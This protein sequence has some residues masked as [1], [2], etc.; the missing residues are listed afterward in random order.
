MF[1]SA[2]HLAPLKQKNLELLRQYQQ[3]HSHKIRNTIVQQNIGLVRKEVYRW[4]HNC[5]ETYEDLLQVGSLGLIR[6]IERFDLSKG[7][8]FS[9]F[10]LP[11]IRGE[12]Q[13]YLRD[14]S[15]C[16]RVPRQWFNLEKKAKNVIHQLQVYLK[17]QP[18]DLEIATQMDISI[19]EWDQIKLASQNRSLLSL[20]APIRDEWEGKISLG[21]L[22]LDSQSF[23]PKISQEEQIDLQQA[24][25]KLTTENRQALEFV[26]LKELT[27]KEAAERLG[28]SA[29]TVSR[30]LKKGLK[31]LKTILTDADWPLNSRAN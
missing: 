27:R 7:Y 9:S 29:I 11:Y 13:H 10:A 2:T 4:L 30:R 25:A 18:T 12:I 31:E 28:V 19:T 24:L 5:S 22:V 21:E 17:R 26:F 16:V 8:A 1:T 14:K 23:N 15:S 3:S 6:A 20:D